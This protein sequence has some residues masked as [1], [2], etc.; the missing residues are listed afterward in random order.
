MAEPETISLTVH[1]ERIKL[2]ASGL[3]TAAGWLIGIALVLP[4][5]DAL[6]G[7]PL[8]WASALELLAMGGVCHLAGFKLLGRLRSPR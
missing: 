7:R 3:G 6:L 2:L 1:N 4:G 5:Y 8:R